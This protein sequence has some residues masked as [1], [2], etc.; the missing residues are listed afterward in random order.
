[1]KLNEEWLRFWEQSEL[2]HG[3]SALGRLAG[4]NHRA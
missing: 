4:L 2:E 3:G 1:V